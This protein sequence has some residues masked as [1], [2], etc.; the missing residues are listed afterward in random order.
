MSPDYNKRQDEYGGSI[1][2]RAG[3]HLQIYHAVRKVVGK[4]YP[5]LIKMNCTD[6]IEN[7]LTIE[8]SLQAAK[9]FADAGFDAI[10]LSGGILRNRKF[11]PTRTGIKTKD[12]EA[13]FR[14]YAREF[15]S[16]IKIP[17]I[18]V[19]GLRSFDVADK[20]IADGMADYIA[21]SRPLI[22][23]PD[24]INRW[25]KG[26]LRKAEC[27]SDNLCFRPGFEGK[28]IYCVTKERMAS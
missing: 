2:N 21:M 18:L 5:I 1:E 13:Y 4:D 27:N 8:D 17:L 26:D 11:S 12:K 19:G 25:E 14:E 7:G 23:E 3:I 10:E 6:F 15:K 16:K 22:R 24:L 20:I 9:L 28:G